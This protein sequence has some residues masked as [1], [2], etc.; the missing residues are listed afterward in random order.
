VAANAAVGITVAADVEKTTTVKTAVVIVI[1]TKIKITAVINHVAT[2][3]IRT[4]AM[5]KNADSLFALTQTISFSE[6]SKPSIFLIDGFFLVMKD[7]SWIIK[8]KS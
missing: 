4:A 3:K 2:I 8:K 6:L 1:V 5:I 7:F